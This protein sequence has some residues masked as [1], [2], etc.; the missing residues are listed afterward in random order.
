MSLPEVPV[1]PPVNFKL[2]N[3]EKKTMKVLVWVRHNK[4]VG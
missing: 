3:K 2:K 1:T 4:W